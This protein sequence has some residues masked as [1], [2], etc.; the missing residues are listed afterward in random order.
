VNCVPEREIEDFTICVGQ[1]VQGS[2]HDQ[3]RLPV[4]RLGLDIGKVNLHGIGVTGDGQILEEILWS[5]DPGAAGH[6]AQAL[7][8]SDGVQPNAEPIGVSQLAHLHVSGDQSVLQ[9][10]GGCNRVTEN[11]LTVIKQ[12]RRVPVVQLR[13]RAPAGAY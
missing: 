5:A 6:V 11:T 3:Q 10:V 8:A 2:H 12:M 9:C 13:D 7:P 1:S 4:A